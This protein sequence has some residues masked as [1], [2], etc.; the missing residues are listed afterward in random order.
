MKMINIHKW[1][2][3][4]SLLLV[5][6]TGF[7]QQ[8]ISL[9]IAAIR[10]MRNTMNGIN[11]S[12]FY[13]FNEHLTGG[14]EINRFFPVNRK[15]LDEEVNMSAWDFDMNLHYILPITKKWKLYPVSGISYTYEN[16]EIREKEMNEIH[17]EHFFSFNTGAGMLWEAG[18]WV[19]HIEYLFTWGKMNQQLLLAGISYEIHWGHKNTESKKTHD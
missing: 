4:L 5:S 8:K 15:T 2:G 14:I 3:L 10:S 16:E 11:V 13:Y 7:A 19:P 18:N 9:D 6:V 17:T 12:S 1:A